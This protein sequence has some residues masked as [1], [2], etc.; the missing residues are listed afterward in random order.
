MNTNSEKKQLSLAVQIFIALVLAIVVGIALQNYAD[1]TQSYIKPF[2]TIFLNL[3]KFI[4]CPIVLVSI[5]SGIISMSDIRKVGSIGAKT[6]IYY[7]CTTAFATC[8]GLAGA[9]IFKRFFPVLATSDLAYEAK[10]AGSFMDTIVNIFPSNFIAPMADASMLQIIV[11]ALI[12]GFSIILVGKEAE[13]VVTLINSLN[14]V[15]MKAMEL[16]IKLSP[17]GVFCLLCPVV[18]SNG[19]MIIGSLAMVLLAAYICYFF[20]GAIIYSTAV[21]VLGGMNPGKFYKGMLPAMMFAFS[22]ASS[23][24]TLPINMECTEELGAS[25]EV[26]SFV[27]PL[28]ATINM[29]GTAI[30]Q[31]VCSVF[32]AA[33]F[34]IDLTFAQMMTIVITATLASIGTAGVPGSGMIML[35]MVLTSVGLPIEGIALVAG[36]DRIFDMGRTV[37]NITGDASAAVI[38]TNMESK[39]AA[40]KAV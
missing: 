30:Y 37:L 20:H 34:G 39:K 32:I 38:V 4:V 31:G 3:L 6:V 5:L 13:P 33:C 28:G 35:T 9:V 27:L 23:V 24:G 26:T 1:F 29:D 40:K 22:S 2:G 36:V 12:I 14:S 15:F 7:L 16:I 21:K 17:I 19:A 18:A 8:I 10:E 25:K 11:A